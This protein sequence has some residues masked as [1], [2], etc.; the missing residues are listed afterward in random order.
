MIVEIAL[1]QYNKKGEYD[2]TIKSEFKEFKNEQEARDFIDKNIE[3][4]YEFYLYNNQ[5]NVDN[6]EHFDVII[7][8]NELKKKD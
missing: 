4:N 3:K 5:E 6:N 2:Y 1:V 8:N 7:A